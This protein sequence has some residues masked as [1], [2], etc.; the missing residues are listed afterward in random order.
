[1]QGFRSLSSLVPIKIFVSHNFILTNFHN[2]IILFIK[3]IIGKSYPFSSNSEIKKGFIRI[4]NH[5]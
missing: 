4:K 1:M 2:K 5:H 3:P